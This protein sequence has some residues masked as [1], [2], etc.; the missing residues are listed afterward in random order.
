[1]FHKSPPPKQTQKPI[2]DAYSNE[3]FVRKETWNQRN[4][5]VDERCAR[6]DKALTELKEGQ[7][8]I[9]KKITATLVTTIGILISVLTAFVVNGLHL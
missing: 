7:D 9:A 4:L 5:T 6:Q 1:M 2:V 8:A 3:V